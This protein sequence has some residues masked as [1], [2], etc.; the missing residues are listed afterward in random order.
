[1]KDK[2]VSTANK[3]FDIVKIVNF[4]TLTGNGDYMIIA[5]GSCCKHI[6]CAFVK[7]ST[8]VIDL[9]ERMN[10]VLEHRAAGSR[11]LK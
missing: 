1:M 9:V 6:C 8:F 7:N 2:S 3:Q 11:L 5:A 10:T 4:G